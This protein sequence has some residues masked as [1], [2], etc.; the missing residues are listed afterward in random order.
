MK[1]ANLKSKFNHD[2][3]DPVEEHGTGGH[4]GKKDQNTTDTIP[5]KNAGQAVTKETYIQEKI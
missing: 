3:H 4:D 5:L 2:G 1:F